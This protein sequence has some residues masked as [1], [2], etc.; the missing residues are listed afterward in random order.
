[1]SDDKSVSRRDFLG[2]AV[3]AAGMGCAAARAFARG[4]GSADRPNIIFIHTDQQYGGML[5]AHGEPFVSTPN[6]DR[7][8]AEGVSFRESYS[9]NP[10]C[11]PA[12]AA[13]YT[14]R[15][16][17]ENGVVM[18]DRWPLMRDMPDLGQ[19]MGSHGYRSV[20][21]GKWHVTGRPL[22]GSFDVITFGHGIGEHGDAAVAR[23]AEGFLRSYEGD[24][25]FFLNLGFL[26][27]HDICYWLFR[28]TLPKD[29]CPYELVDEDLPPLP[30]S[31]QYD[32]REPEFF[33][34]HWRDGGAAKHL[35]NWKPW[36]WR[37]YRWAYARH[38]EMVDAHIGR[39][40]N[41][42]E[43]SRFADNTL[44]VFTSD[45]GDGHGRH[46]MFSKMYFYEEAAL[47]PMIVRFPGRTGEGIQDTDHLVSGLDVAPTLCDYA[48]IEAPPKARG[49][50]LRPLVEGRRAPWREF[51]VS[52]AH[53]IGR[54]VRTPEY[55]FI[56]YEGSPT[57]QLFDMRE[58][59]LEQL[60]LAAEGTHDGVVA[61]LRKRLREWD[62]HLEHPE[63]K[64]IER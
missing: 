28:N 26:Q 7:L 36:Q 29:E 60:N 13:W 64:P 14:G 17:T 18:N 19:W 56:T 39:V 35:G 33:R 48:G 54:M 55:K 22:R 59:R 23:A 32:E 43:D 53:R 4:R 41:S 16:S 20:Y 5:S 50:S 25:P 42:L 30:D 37:Y 2:R 24:E 58:D 1:M 62:A 49:L 57:E 51:L 52:E 31:W 44:V 11:C 12:R 6:M 40:L 27:P 21:A 63:L 46:H 34:Q 8:A 45:H 15:P 10:V 3:G 38:V 47:V 61:D 9:A